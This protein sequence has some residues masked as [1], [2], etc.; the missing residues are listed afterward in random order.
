MSKTPHILLQHARYY[1]R[2]D[3]LSEVTECDYDPVVGAWVT[4]RTNNSSL[5]VE[6]D[7]LGRPRPLTKKAD[8]ET[9]EDRKGD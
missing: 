8:V 9:G 5:L 7:G 3:L 1:P 2:R 6:N 4:S